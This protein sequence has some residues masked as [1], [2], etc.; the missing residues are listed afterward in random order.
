MENFTSVNWLAVVV[1]AILSFLLGWLWYSPKLF[2][3]KWAVGSGV[4][5]ASAEKMPVFAL[6]AQLAALVGLSTVV[7]ITATVNALFTAILVIVTA[8]LF[9]TS[10]G[11]FVKKTQYAIRV[12]VFYILLAGALMIVCQG[13]L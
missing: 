10:S 2:G 1:G 6:A 12:D 7:G 13:L 3:T 9:V 11:A 8:A 5:L 4:S